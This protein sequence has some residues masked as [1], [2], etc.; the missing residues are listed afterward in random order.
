MQ[1]LPH[2]VA[3]LA[4]F[5]FK[6]QPKIP[7][8]GGSHDGSQIGRAELSRSSFRDEALPGGKEDMAI[9]RADVALVLWSESVRLQRMPMYLRKPLPI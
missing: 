8:N 4:C 3:V 2:D 5:L 6:Q 1:A 9:R 7:S